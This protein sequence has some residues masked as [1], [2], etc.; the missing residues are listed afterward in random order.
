MNDAEIHP[1]PPDVRAHL[2]EEITLDLGGS[3]NLRR[4]ALRLIT[5]IEARLADWAMV[6]MP[7]GRTGELVAVGAADS[8]GV[9]LRRATLEGLPLGRILHTGRTEQLVGSELSGLVPIQPF[10]ASAMDLTPAEVLGLGLTARGGT[11]GA[12][13]LLRRANAGFATTSRSPNSSPAAPRWLW[14]RPGCMRTRPGSRRCCSRT[15]GDRACPRSRVSAWPPATAPRPNTST[16]AAISTRSAVA[17]TTGSSPS[18]TCAA[19]A[20]KRRR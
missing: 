14:T 16:W 11:F 9:V 19:R 18:A 13:V 2:A 7:D 5:L 1:S 8:G 17:T 6:V 4:S 12:L 3:L 20:W 10:H 15:C